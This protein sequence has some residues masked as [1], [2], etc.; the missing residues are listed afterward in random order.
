MSVGRI[1][2]R[3]ATPILELAEEK[4]VLDNVKTDMESF[5]SVCDDNRD[6]SLMLKS[7][8]IPHQKKADILKKVFTG[9]VNDLT[10]QAFDIITRKSRENLLEDIAEEFLHLY[11]VKKGLAEVSVT[12]SIELDADMK[13]AFEKLA[14]DI[15]GKDP[16]LS[17]KVD[18]EIVGGYILRMG[19]LQLDESVSGQLKDLK[20]KFS[21]K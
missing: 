5:I 6:F 14:K 4:K 1:A 21:K 18:P 12:T 20:L 11:N 17:E 2:V 9:K 15:T 13:K 7:P 8:I 3:Y 16:L 10:L 19:D